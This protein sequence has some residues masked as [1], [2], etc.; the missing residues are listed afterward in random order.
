MDGCGWVDVDVDVDGWIWMMLR[1]KMNEGR[2]WV[3]YTSRSRVASPPA[4]GAP[5]EDK[6]K[7]EP[8]R[9]PWP[10]RGVISGITPFLPPHLSQNGFLRLGPLHLDL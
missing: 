9:K 1:V 5:K 6:M 4:K 2:V 10:G 8:P 7:R 3:L